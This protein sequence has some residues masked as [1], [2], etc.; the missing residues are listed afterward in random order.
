MN[1]VNHWAYLFG[2][3]I[4]SSCTPTAMQVEAI[5]VDNNGIEINEFSLFLVFK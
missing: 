3:V 5:D 1:V 2:L 4:L